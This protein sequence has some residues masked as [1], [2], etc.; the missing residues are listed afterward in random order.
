VSFT[1]FPPNSYALILG[2]SSGFGAATAIE[3]A[4]HGVGTIGVHL[5]R[6]AT[7]PACEEVQAKIRSYGVEAHFFN[8]NAADAEQRTTVLDRITERFAER[9]GASIRTMVHSLAFGALKPFIADNPREELTQAQIEMTM[10]VMASSLVYWTQDVVRRGLIEQG[11]RIFAMTS[12]GSHRVLPMYGAVSAAKAALESYCRQLAFELG[13]KG[14]MVNS[15]QAGVTYTPALAKIPGNDFLMENARQR[16]PHHRLTTPEDVA[17]TIVLLSTDEAAW[18]NGSV[19]HVDGG[20][21]A[22]DV[23]WLETTEAAK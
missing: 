19:V 13:P 20:E 7:M 11:G 16:N 9:S 18:I 5:D 10:N 21:D 15:I 3:F 4:R 2:A 14:V 1:S 17:R 23:N 6:A 12:A 22:V 8:I